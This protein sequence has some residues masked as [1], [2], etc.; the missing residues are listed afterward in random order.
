[1]LRGAQLGIPP[2]EISWCEAA[3]ACHLACGSGISK[4]YVPSLV[5]DILGNVNRN[6]YMNITYSNLLLLD[7]FLLIMCDFNFLAV[8]V[9]HPYFCIYCFASLLLVLCSELIHENYIL[10]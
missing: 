3:H 4:I 8:D 10:G 2:G 1:M 5:V 9:V 7:A 6:S